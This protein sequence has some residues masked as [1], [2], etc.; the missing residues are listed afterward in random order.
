MNVDD[1]IEREA[2]LIIEIL[3]YALGSLSVHEKEL[4]MKTIDKLILLLKFNDPKM[5]EIVISMLENLKRNYG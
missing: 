5:N 3:A 4:T 1:T 2:L